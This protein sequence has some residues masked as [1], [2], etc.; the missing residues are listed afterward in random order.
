MYYQERCPHCVNA[1][2]ALAKELS[3]RRIIAHDLKNKKD[4][5]EFIKLGGTGVP[6]FVS[7]T[8]HQTFSGN[9]KTFDMLLKKLNKKPASLKDLRVKIFVSDSCGY[10]KRLK[11]MLSSTHNLQ[12]VELISTSDSAFEKESKKYKF[13]GYPFIVSETTGKHILGAPPSIEKMMTALQ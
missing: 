10:C 4:Y 8:T 11:Q 3:S 1:K 2:Q 13:N 9:P 6:F 12:N 7:K 5:D